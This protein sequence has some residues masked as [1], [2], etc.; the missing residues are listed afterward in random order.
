MREFSYNEPDFAFGQTMLS[1][2]TVINLTQSS[3]AE[4]L[5]VSRRAVGDWEAGNKYPKAANLK[6]FIAF[7]IKHQAFEAGREAEEI[8]SLWRATRQ[9]TQLD[10]ATLTELVSNARIPPLNQTTVP[11]A[12]SSPVM[13]KV[14]EGPKLDWGEAPSV[15]TF[16]GREAEFSELKKWI[17]EEQCRV[18]SLLGLGGIGKSALA[19]SFM[20]QVAERF[21][22][23]IWRSVRDAPDC[24]TLLNGCL[25]ILA[26]EVLSE[27]SFSFEQQLSL[28]LEQLRSRRVLVVLDNLET[29]LQEGQD[30]GYLQRGYESYGRVLR[31]IAETSH[32]SCLLLTSREKLV[33]LAPMEGSLSPVRVQRLTQLD[34]G[35]CEQLLIAKDVGGTSSQRMQLSAVFA[36]NPLALKMVAQTIVNLFDGEIAPFL[37]Q[38][39]IIFGEVRELFDQ[40]FARLSPL[41]QTVLGRLASISEPATLDELLTVVGRPTPRVRLLEAVE[42]L[43]RRS[44][45]ERGEKPGSFTVQSVVLEYVTAQLVAAGA[46]ESVR[47]NPAHLL[48]QSFRPGQS[49]L[50]HN[51]LSIGLVKKQPRYE[52]NRLLTPVA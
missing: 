22:V 45:I 49:K 6:Q 35:A 13:V 33:D 1:L 26:P 50:T 38:G 21:E 15:P 9:K 48:N 7:A 14:K 2:R 4:Y 28:L 29:L 10:E 16:Y 36:G 40:Q 27:R 30:T 31:R 8:R 5:G 37:E 46:D 43:H 41:E 32:Q 18:V 47:D 44:L 34:S 42:S 11:V 23:V 51:K 52:E 20:H 17:V 3:L 39:E 25:Q 12:V 24:E 19:V